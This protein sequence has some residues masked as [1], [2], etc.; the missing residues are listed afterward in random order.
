MRLRLRRHFHVAERIALLGG[1]ADAARDDLGNPRYVGAAAADQ[2]LVGLRAATAGRK[3]ELQRAADLLGHVVDERVEHLGLIVAGQAALFL[4]AARLLH[5]KTVGAH[6]LLGELL[7]AEGKIARIDDLHVAQH[8][9][10]G[11][12]CAEVDH[13]H[14]AVDAPVRHLMAHERT[15][16]LQRERLDVDDVRGQ[17][18]SLH[19]GLPLLHV[20]GARRNQQHIQHV[21]VLLGGTHDL[22]VVADLLHREGDV[23]IGLHLDLALELVLPEALGHLNDL[24]DGGV[25]R[26]GDGGE[27]ALGARSV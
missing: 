19:R 17:A 23:L 20:L 12:R 7:P 5:G 25:A 10:R 13:G 15:G 3:V 2:D 22:I 27:A 9:E 24:G 1:N 6:D 16:V 18:G 21:R 11:A 26:D 8:A 4:G 14:G